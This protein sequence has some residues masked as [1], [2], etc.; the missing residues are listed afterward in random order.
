MISIIIHFQSKSA[1]QQARIAQNVKKPEKLLES[2]GPL[3]DTTK[4]G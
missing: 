3:V 2:F 4:N 1:T